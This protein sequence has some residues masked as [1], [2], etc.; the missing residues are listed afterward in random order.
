[1]ALMDTKL[2]METNVTM[3]CELEIFFKIA[4]ALG[5]SVLTLDS[6]VMQLIKFVSD[7][8]SHTFTNLSSSFWR[9]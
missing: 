4:C 2:I 3:K 1:M 5:D 9:T 8:S 6:R 7:F